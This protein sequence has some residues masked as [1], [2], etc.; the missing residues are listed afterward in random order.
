MTLNQIQVASRL[1][2]LNCRSIEYIV[3]SPKFERAFE[4]CTDK[5]LIYKY[6]ENLDPEN[7][8]LLIERVLKQ[9]LDDKSLK[10]VREVAGSLGILNYNQYNKAEL[11]MLIKR[12]K[13]AK[14]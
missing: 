10:D 8:K 3:N 9:N 11:I 7:L 1:K 6:I 2:L 4:L 5:T 14:S 12:L 13:H